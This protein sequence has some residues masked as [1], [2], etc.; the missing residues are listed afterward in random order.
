VLTNAT[1][2]NA[3]ARG[4]EKRLWDGQRGLY[5][6][7]TTAGNKRW[8]VKYKHQGRT[9]ITG[10][11]NWPDVGLQQAREK[12]IDLQRAVKEGRDPVNERRAQKK[13]EAL[14]RRE[15]LNHAAAAEHNREGLDANSFEAV[16]WR[17]FDEKWRYGK[18]ERHVRQQEQRLEKNII[19]HIGTR[20]IA[21]IEAL[22]LV[23]MALAIEKHS[24]ELARRSLAVC[25]AI[26]RY[27]V[28]HSLAPRNT[29][30]DI[31][32]SDFLKAKIVVNQ[33]RIDAKDA[34]ALMDAIGGYPVPTTRAA[35][36]MIHY[37][38]VRASELAGARFDEFEGLDTDAPMWKIPGE[39]MKAGRE[40]WVPC[41]PQV[42]E[43]VGERRMAHPRSEYL[44]PGQ[45]KSPH[46][47]PG[48]LLLALERLGYRGK[49]S[50]HGARGLASTVLH[51]HQFAHEAIE[52]QLA[53]AD[54]DKVSAAYNHMKLIEVRREM[55]NWYARYL[56]TAMRGKVVSIAS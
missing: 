26:F 3:K 14:K 36:L 56:D 5:L 50:A 22:E 30:K 34:G 8:C 45:G 19:P 54:E 9:R 47:H 1:V 31:K 48:T 6:V 17:W 21:E 13:R 33:P 18:A 44:F 28:V 39:R 11:G 46:L 37:T 27:A 7:V 10:L 35:L 16:A 40:H 41:S 53:H 51:E 12:A 2:K 42:A 49:H 20:L 43:I 23:H 38:F 25:E 52:L 15:A 32:A 24:P 55:M 29:A 4:K